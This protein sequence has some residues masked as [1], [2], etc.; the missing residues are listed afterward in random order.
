MRKSALRIGTVCAML[1]ALVTPGCDDGGGNGAST[2]SSS[3]TSGGAGGGN[4]GAGGGA[5]TGGEGGTAGTGG[6]TNMPFTSEGPSNYESQTQIV[7]DTKGNLVAA[8]MAFSTNGDSAIGYAVSRDGGLNWTAPKTIASPNGRLASNPVLAIDGQGRTTL[9]WLGF[10]LDFNNPDEH[11]YASRLDP[12]TETFGTPVIASDDGTKT[13][14]DFDKPAIVVDANDNLLLTWADFTG[15]NMGLPASLTFA[16][17][18]DGQTF[19]RS[20]VTADATFGNLATVC[21]DRSQGPT[22]P[23][24]MVHL[25]ANGTVTLRVSTDQGQ[26]WQLRSTPAMA[27]LFQDI[28]CVANGQTL[29]VAYASGNGGFMPG[30]D[31]AADSVMVMRSKDGGMTFDMPVAAAKPA[32]G[33]MMLYPRIARSASGKLGVVYYQGKV[34]AAANMVLAS[35]MDGSTWST[36]PVANTGTLTLDRTIASWLGGYVGFAIA[37]EKGYVTYADNSANKT[38]VHYAEIALP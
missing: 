3:S 12:Q 15:S 28:T 5:N 32:A 27:T 30:Y 25:G 26:T 22:A 2:T 38:H 19:T 37:G 9:A 24:Y 4:G 33:E 14:L 21:L 17:S 16:R 20:T 8:W 13:T 29:W 1:S 11:I 6:G 31:T 36:S 35:S 10:A 7:A 23:L 34:D 18:V